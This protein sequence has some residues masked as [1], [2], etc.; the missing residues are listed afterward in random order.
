MNDHA[1]SSQVPGALG[2]DGEIEGHRPTSRQ[3]RATP[4]R[5]RF[6]LLLDEPLT[7]EGVSYMWLENR[8]G[9]AN[10]PV[11]EQATT[12]STSDEGT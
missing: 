6:G 3:S 5:S 11:P 7:M 12:P 4:K 10:S 2:G 9:R 1:R 8:T